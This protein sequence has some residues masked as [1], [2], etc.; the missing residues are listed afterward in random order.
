MRA[1]KTA[2][3]CVLCGSTGNIEENH[4]GGRNFLPQLTMPYCKQHHDQF[5]IAARQAGID[6]SRTE[7][8]LVRFV[9]A[10]KLLVLAAWQL[11]D[12]LERE[13]QPQG[14]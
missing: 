3:Q 10:M 9:R 7:N 13:I 4:A 1:P 11:L 12:E 14:E 6:L 5:H 8:P 2:K